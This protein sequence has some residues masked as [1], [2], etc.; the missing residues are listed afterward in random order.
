MSWF[1]PNRAMDD[2]VLLRKL[3]R[4]PKGARSDLLKVL[5]ADPGVR[6]D[7]FRQFYERDDTRN[8]AEVLMDLETDDVLR[9]T[10]IGLLDRLQPT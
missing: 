6:A 10:V 1:P 9:L 3:R 5:L 2:E 8:L 7:L 4:L